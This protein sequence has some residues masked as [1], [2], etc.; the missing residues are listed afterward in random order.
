MYFK[1]EKNINQYANII[2][3][4]LKNIYLIKVYFIFS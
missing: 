3:I 2:I 1:Q 4:S